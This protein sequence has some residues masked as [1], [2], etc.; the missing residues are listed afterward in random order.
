MEEGMLMH[1]MDLVKWSMCDTGLESH[2]L[3]AP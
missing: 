1:Q 3:E 2:L